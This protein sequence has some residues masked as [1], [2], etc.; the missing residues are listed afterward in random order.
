MRLIVL[1]TNVIVS[2][3]LN[4]DGA[5]AKVVMDHALAGLVRVAT[6]PCVVQEYREVVQ[7]PKFAR[8]KFP[9]PWLELLIGQGLQLPDPR[10]WPD[11]LPDPADAPFLALAHAAGA[12][13]VTGNLKHFPAQ[14]RHG[15]TV[16][17]PAEYLDTLEQRSKYPR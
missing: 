8:F 17:S 16:V 14:A 12:W 13:L 9:P 15:V 2:A 11:T 5:P 6:C 4:P 3:R 10:P 1:D 7:R